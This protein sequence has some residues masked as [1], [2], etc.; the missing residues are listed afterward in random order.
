MASND[1]LSFVR[2][3]PRGLYLM[4]NAISPNSASVNSTSVGGSGTV[5]VGELGEVGCVKVA[6]AGP[7]AVLAPAIEKIPIMEPVLI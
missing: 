3:I 1:A 2:R 5:E 4:L 7:E 6:V